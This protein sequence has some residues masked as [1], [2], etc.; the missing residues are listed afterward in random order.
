[1]RWGNP[2]HTHAHHVRRPLVL[3]RLP[4]TFP[5][6]ALRTGLRANHTPRTCP[7]PHT[8]ALPVYLARLRPWRRC[9][10]ARKEEYSSSSSSRVRLL[11]VRIQQ[12]YATG[13]L[14]PRATR[15]LCL[16][17]QRIQRGAR[18][19]WSP[20]AWA[21]KG[22]RGWSKGSGRDATSKL[23][24]MST[25]RGP[26]AS[27]TIAPSDTAGRL[28]LRCRTYH[29]LP[30]PSL[31]LYVSNVSTSTHPMMPPPSIPSPPLRLSLA[32]H[33]KHREQDKDKRGRRGGGSRL[34]QV[35]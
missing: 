34:L 23:G 11:F 10:S 2:T 29:L 26:P 7:L 4:S 15:D 30:S 5:Q 6:P 18:M 14:S 24:Q 13:S 33:H 31:A 27:L 21:G 8:R 25:S 17:G 9:C 32:S 1:M 12:C 20:L 3:R 16:R 28:Y 35:R 19:V 22:E